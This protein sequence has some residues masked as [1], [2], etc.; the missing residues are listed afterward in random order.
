MQKHLK[1]NKNRVKKEI[2][3][4]SRR[5]GE[6]YRGLWP[7]E[8]TLTTAFRESMSV[9]QAS[10]VLTAA[11][12]QWSAACAHGRSAVDGCQ[13]EPRNALKIDLPELYLHK[14]G[15]LPH[16]SFRVH[17]LCHFSSTY[18]SVPGKERLTV[19]QKMLKE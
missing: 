2:Q 8:G 4:C 5:Q 7:R 17:L 1:L 16:F 10:N 13:R 12:C 15:Q 11:A 18:F 6:R 14:P 9:S 19:I 3:P